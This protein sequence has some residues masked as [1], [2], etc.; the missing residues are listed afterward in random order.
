MLFPIEFFVLNLLYLLYESQ[1]K[2]SYI[3]DRLNLETRRAEYFLK[4]IQLSDF[5]SKVFWVY[6][7][8]AVYG[9]GIKE[10]TRKDISLHFEQNEWS[11]HKQRN[12]ENRLEDEALIERIGERPAKF[13]LSPYF[14]NMLRKA[15]PPID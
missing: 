10:L 13:R 2:I 12:A 15:N 5:E 14:H 11:E 9:S 3:L 8:H 1:E 7:D 4:D 6:F